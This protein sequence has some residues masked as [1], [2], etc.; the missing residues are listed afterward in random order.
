MK[1]LLLLIFS[2]ILSVNSYAEWTKVLP[3]NSSTLYIDFKTLKEEDGFINWWYIDSWSTGSAKSYAQGDCDLKG[4]RILKRVDY[5]F[6]MGEGEG[7]EK[8][9]VTNWEY[10]QANTG[11]EIL[12][13][14]ICQMSK[15]SPQEQSVR[16][17]ILEKRNEEFERENLGLSKQPK[18]QIS[19]QLKIL[20]SSYID[21]INAKIKSVWFYPDAEEN[22]SCDV[23]IN[24]AENGA[25]E[26]VKIIECEI[27][28]SQNPEVSKSKAQLFANSIRRA[29]FKS[30][31][32]PPA[33]NDALFNKRVM[34]KFTVDK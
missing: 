4:F 18:E 1:K 8:D 14:F 13:N 23:L 27:G 29:I 7:T 6:P 32:L 34:V 16:I 26:A 31:P 20:K 12:L 28:K 24:Q 11:Y 15:L 2:L 25:V 9:M 17:E 10:Y 22:W 3:G 19:P 33:P 5:S 30:S 21:S